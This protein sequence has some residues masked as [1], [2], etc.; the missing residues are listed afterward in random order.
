MF[1][2]LQGH[3][4]AGSPDVALTLLDEMLYLGLEPDRLTYNALI[5]AHVKTE[6]LD[7]AMSFHE[8]LKV[9]S[10]YLKAQF[11]ASKCFK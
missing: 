10:M 3:I 7:V 4:S 6:K 8:Q 11:C 9:A 5:L 1:Y 2:N